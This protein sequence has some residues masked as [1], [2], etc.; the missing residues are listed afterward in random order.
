[1]LLSAGQISREIYFIVEGLMRT[2][3]LIDGKEVTTYLSCDGGLI[4]AY[5]GFINQTASYEYI[6]CLEDSELLAISY[7]KMQKL[8]HEIPAWEKV[9]RI[10]AEQNYL[11]MADRVL[12][13]QMIPAK[14]KYLNFIETQAPKIVQQTPLIHIASFL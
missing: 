4:S 9:G 8:Y 10:L 11:C 1:I 3:H 2:Y 12:K 13:L 14:E 7:D 6:Q 5:S